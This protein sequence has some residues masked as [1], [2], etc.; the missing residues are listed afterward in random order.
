V[1]K[2]AGMMSSKLVDTYHELLL[3]GSVGVKKTAKIGLPILSVFLGEGERDCRSTVLGVYEKCWGD[4]SRLLQSLTWEELEEKTNEG[5]TTDI[6]RA[7]DSMLR[8]PELQTDGPVGK[9]DNAQTQAY[10]AYYI[11]LT[12][13]RL[14]SFFEC[15]KLE[16]AIND[17]V[18]V[19][20]IV[21][22]L[23]DLS[24]KRKAC[25]KDYLE[26]LYGWAEKAKAC[27]ICMSDMSHSRPLFGEWRAEN[28]RACADF[29]LLIA[30]E[31]EGNA[32][33]NKSALVAA[34][35]CLRSTCFTMGYF[36]KGKDT[37][38][39]AAQTFLVLLDELCEY[40]KCK[41]NGGAG[42]I[43]ERM[44]YSSND[45][46]VGEVRQWSDGAFSP[47]LRKTPFILPY[48]DELAELDRRCS[49]KNRFSLIKKS[50]IKDFDTLT[51]NA[52][53]SLENLGIWSLYYEEYYG[54]PFDN[55]YKNGGKDKITQEFIKKISAHSSIEAMK[56]WIPR[57][58]VRLQSL[59]LDG[60]SHIS[61][62]SLSTFADCIAD[63]AENYTYDSIVLP[64][65]TEC[66]QNALTELNESIKRFDKIVTDLR[67]ELG[68]TPISESIKGSYGL[69][70]REL[71]R[72]NRDF[73]YSNF[74]PCNEEDFR[75]ELGDLLYKLIDMDSI[76][77]QSVQDDIQFQDGKI[78]IKGDLTERI[79]TIT[80]LQC[81]GRFGLF[82]NATGELDYGVDCIFDTPW[83]DY[84]EEIAVY[85]IEPSDIKWW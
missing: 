42:R 50:I 66:L 76:Y 78:N 63:Y 54:V 51:K 73:L 5:R 24:D 40:D 61:T 3:P 12:D 16:P 32:D 27:L 43:F 13:E 36:S 31:A 20:K 56:T 37:R 72:G 10:I 57:E 25:R 67:E 48:T 70:C 14:E 6:T 2:V 15:I 22:I 71:V 18:V 7:L 45:E 74:H 68:E 33:A 38:A 65:I 21:F 64:K 81:T 8:T 79:P 30:S 39:I 28:C 82:S 77:R 29:M 4:S 26:R 11:D 44:G 55:W 23:L 62:S 17:M 41:G 85:P 9:A 83:N 19:K 69:R 1:F 75:T 35:N 58:S 47:E 34:R 46:L 80:N 52:V 60:V 59:V 49:S 84:I 53:L